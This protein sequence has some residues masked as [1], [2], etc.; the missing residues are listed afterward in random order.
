MAAHLEGKGLGMIDMAGLA[1]GRRGLQP[2]APRQASGGH[3][4]DPRLGGHGPPR[5]GLRSRR[6]RHQ[7]GAGLGEGRAERPRREHRGGDAGRRRNAADFSL[8]AE[9]IKRA[10]GA[11]AK[12]RTAPSSTPRRSRRRCSA[13][14][15]PPTCSCWAMPIG[16][17]GAPLSAAAIEKAIELNREAVK[18]NLA[19]FAWGRARLGAGA[20][21]RLM[22][23]LK[24]PTPSRKLSETL[25][26]V[27]HAASSSSP[28]TRA[29]ATRGA[30]RRR[31][32]ACAK[33][34]RKS[35]PA[36]RR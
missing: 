24:A 32:S 6:H 7:E 25:D 21:A 9:R 2:R 1:E 16:R 31:W 28:A 36:A 8:P 26:E 18:M 10:I 12:V 29:R 13:M 22:S 14:P 34:R 23:E 27:D 19:A 30:T 5:A 3:P 4:R 11:A 20:I 15:S 17:S 35:C 33:R